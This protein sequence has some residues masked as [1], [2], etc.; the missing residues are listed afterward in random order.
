[1][2]I[3]NTCPLC[4][5]KINQNLKQLRCRDK[6]QYNIIKYSKY[7]ID[8]WIKNH[9][10]CPICK[11]II[12]YSKQLENVENKQKIVN[13]NIP[14]YNFTDSEEDYLVCDSLSDDIFNYFRENDDSGL[15]SDSD[16]DDE[17]D[18]EFVIH[19]RTNFISS[20]LIKERELDSNLFPPEIQNFVDRLSDP[21]KNIK[22]SLNISEWKNL[23][24]ESYNEYKSKE[25]NLPNN[26]P[27]KRKNNSESTNG[28]KTRRINGG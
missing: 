16:S 8:I 14:N 12:D 6:F 28:D 20:R 15:E 5:K 27:N 2:N 19:E 1:M 10:Y 22:N 11:N 25:N 13:R 26:L 17:S 18:N 21:I 24:L 9:N 4:Y 3:G 23:I 7:C